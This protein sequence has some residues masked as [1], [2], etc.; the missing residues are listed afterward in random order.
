MKLYKLGISSIKG[1][2]FGLL[3]LLTLGCSKTNV[4][5]QQDADIIRLKHLKYYANLLSEYNTATGKYPFEGESNLPTY[6]HIAN[7][8]QIEYTRPGA[9]Y[10]HEEISFKD[11]VTELET[12]LDKEVNEYYDPQYRPDYKPNF[13]VYLING[14]TYYLAVHVHQPFP[15]AEKIAEHYYKV[16]LSNNPNRVNR[17]I[18]PQQLLGSA[19]FKA[20]LEKT[21]RK[22]GFFQER[23][24]KYLN[25]TDSLN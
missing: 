22:P 6:V 5:F 16:E 24:N 1:I 11:F 15:F 20:E 7:N 10:P 13:Y 25:H 2:F 17:A 3:L 12:T 18:S 21:M 9:P 19:E 14:D 8:E 4:G 23:E